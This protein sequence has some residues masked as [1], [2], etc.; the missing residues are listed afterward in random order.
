MAKFERQIGD[1]KV[2][3]EAP[4]GVPVSGVQ[5]T[6]TPEDRE[7]FLRAADAVG[8]IEALWMPEDDGGYRQSAAAHA[9]HED[10]SRDMN[11]SVYIREPPR[12]EKEPAKLP[13]HPFFG[14]LKER[15]EREAG[16]GS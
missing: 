7:T 3:V 2:T 1:V 13:P 11:G 14:P 5:V 9:R 10:G 6:V 15:A 8:G 4:D 16:V 12:D